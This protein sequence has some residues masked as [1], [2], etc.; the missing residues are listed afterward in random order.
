MEVATVLYLRIDVSKNRMASETHPS[1]FCRPIGPG[2][3]F[4]NKCLV[5]GE[6]LFFIWSIPETE[7]QRHLAPPADKQK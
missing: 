4:R 7:R 6:W 3:A 1:F 5:I 2:V